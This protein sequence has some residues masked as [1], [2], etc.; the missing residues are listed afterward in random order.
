MHFIKFHY[1][2]SRQGM[3]NLRSIYLSTTVIP[4]LFPLRHYSRRDSGRHKRWVRTTISNPTLTNAVFLY[5]GLVFTQWGHVLSATYR[6]ASSSRRPSSTWMVPPRWGRCEN[7]SR[8]RLIDCVLRTL[9][10]SLCVCS[11]RLHHQMLTIL[12]MARKSCISKDQ[13]GENRIRSANFVS[14][15]NPAAIHFLPL[16][17]GTICT[18][19]FQWI[20]QI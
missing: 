12:W 13:S 15:Q 18:E 9:S 6:E 8:T 7:T 4:S 19:Y 2:W 10:S 5:N 3:L 16:F 20:V 14:I 17:L 1:P 11:V